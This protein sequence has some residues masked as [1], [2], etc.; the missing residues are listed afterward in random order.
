MKNKAGW[1]LALVFFWACN[2]EKKSANE[3]SGHN[4]TD[5]NSHYCD[6]V[7]NGLIA[8]DTLKGSP[9]RTAM[10]TVNGTHIH[11]EY[12]S[13]GV[14]GRTIWG[15]LVPYDK[16]WVTGAH[17]ATRV[18]FSKEVVINGIRIPAGQ[19]AFF[20]IPGK[21]KW[22]VILNTRYDQHQTDEYN[23]KEDVMRL[24]VKPEEQNMTQRL[25]YTVEK[26]NSKS[27]EIKMQWEKILIRVPFMTN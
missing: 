5:G 14:K 27:G 20:T 6:S 12:S 9:L 11:V 10:T 22:T 18:Q 3:H 26:I 19:Y 8:T 24:E 15:G 17:K 13:P 25:I 4:M 7:N 21:E 23:E 1:L 16:V 2:N